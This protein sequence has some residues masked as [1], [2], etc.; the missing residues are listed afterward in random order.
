MVKLLPTSD[1]QLF[2]G[3]PLSETYIQE[4]N[5]LDP[6]FLDAFIKAQSSD[7]LQRIENQG[8]VYL[9]KGIPS[10]YDVAGL[11]SLQTNIMSL[12]IKL[13]PDYPYA[14]HPLQLFVLS[15]SQS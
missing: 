9:G 4:L 12:L 14:E 7:Y 5:Q 3:L 15:S 6:P 13:V 2:L 8:V 1:P 11:E 10:P